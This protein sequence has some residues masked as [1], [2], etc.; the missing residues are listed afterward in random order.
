MEVEAAGVAGEA[1][2]SETDGA[3]RQRPQAPT[4]AGDDARGEAGERG[5]Q[6]EP[7]EVAQDKDQ[8]SRF[9]MSGTFLANISLTAPTLPEI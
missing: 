3:A 6:Q 4:A 5:G 1:P 2:V 9:R 8:S 7:A